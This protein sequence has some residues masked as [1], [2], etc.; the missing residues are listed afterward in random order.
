MN[1]PISY[2]PKIIVAPDSFKGVLKAPEAALAIADGVRKGLRKIFPYRECRIETIPVADGGEGT[3]EVLAKACGALPVEVETLSP[4]LEPIKASYHFLPNEGDECPRAFIDLAAASGLPLVPPPRRNP[5]DTSTF[6]TGILIAD[7][8]RR[9]ARDII[10]GAGGSATVDGGAGAL[11]ALGATFT[12]TEGTL[13]TE[14]L[15]GLDLERIAGINTIP[16]FMRDISITIATDVT[17]PL[18]GPTGAAMVFAPQKGASREETIYLDAALGKFAHTLQ[19][20]GFADVASLSGSGA[21]G[22]FAA[23]MAAVA[24]AILRPGALMVLDAVEMADRLQ[25][26]SL[27]ITGEGCADGQTLMEKA[28]FATMRMARESRMPVL[29]L[30]G[31]I[32][33][34]ERLMDAGFTDVIDI[35][36][37]HDS[38]EDS[39]DPDIA[40]RRLEAA[41]F[42]AVC[43]LF[44]TRN[45]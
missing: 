32:K 37:G 4:L 40:R 24:G 30:A 9:G 34:K 22:G 3:A 6:G 29:L 27:M 14:P 39:L 28:P 5:L 25:G 12:D 16:G 43:R 1:L 33:E 21:A 19:Q 26:A 31:R 38:G 7:A 45:A 11:Q 42:N 23:G 36:E 10:I 20:C 18:T 17:A 13:M 8:I 35:N 2:V 15:R 44:Q 41:A